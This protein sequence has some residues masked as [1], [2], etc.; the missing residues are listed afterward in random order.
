MYP[1]AGASRLAHVLA[2]GRAMVATAMHHD[3]G[4]RENAV[5]E[6]VEAKKQMVYN[7]D[8][9][10]TKFRQFLDERIRSGLLS[11]KDA[12]DAFVDVLRS[13]ALDRK[14]TIANRIAKRK[15]DDMMKNVPSAEKD[16]IEALDK[17][18]EYM[19]PKTAFYIEFV[20]GSMDE[21]EREYMLRVPED[22]LDEIV[23]DRTGV[24]RNV[25]F[26]ETDDDEPDNPE[27][28]RAEALRM[29][30]FRLNRLGVVDRVLGEV[31]SDDL[32]TI[33]I[34]PDD[35]ADPRLDKPSDNAQRQRLY[36]QLKRHLVRRGSGQNHFTMSTEREK[37][38][39]EFDDSDS[40]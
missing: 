24:Q 19:K 3:G 29:V 36:V 8:L 20:R 15:Y 11:P 6:E 31:K 23:K 17:L 21:A 1:A 12:D 35:E 25:N 26:M 28:L 38:L 9:T 4:P 33:A 10:L 16:A 30:I 13:P 18:L 14:R 7:G 2:V 39:M 37:A 32:P 5:D 22:A 27:A 40:D 34:K